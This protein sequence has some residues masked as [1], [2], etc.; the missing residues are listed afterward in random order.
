MK[1]RRK[2]A[3]VKPKPAA[4]PRPA[5]SARMASRAAPIELF[6]WPTPNGWKISIML[7]ECGLPYVV[8]PVDISRG[9]Q[10]AKKFLAISPNNRIPAIV[11]PD[12]PGGRPISVFESGAILQ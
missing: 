12:G 3:T 8:R 5:K 9:E 10:F 1:R 2:I 4:K 11:D 6:Y 7:E